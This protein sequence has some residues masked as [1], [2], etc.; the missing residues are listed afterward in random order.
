VADI[1]VATSPRIDLTVDQPNNY[2]FNPELNGST[3]NYS[4]V[5]TGAP[6]FDFVKRTSDASAAYAGTSGVPLDSFARR[7]AFAL[8]FSDPNIV[9]SQ[10]ITDQSRILYMRR[11]T[12]RVATSA[13]FLSFDTNSYPVVVQGH[14]YSVIDAYTTSEFYPNSQRY[15]SGVLG[16][17]FK[18]HPFNYIR[19]SVKAVVDTYDGSVTLYVVDKN[20][21]VIE[22]Y[23]TAFPELFTDA[24]EISSELRAHLRYP[25]DIFRVQTDMWG[26]YHINDANQ[27]YNKENAWEPPPPPTDRPQNIGA[28]AAQ[29]AQQ[30]LLAQPAT[31]KSF[32]RMAPPR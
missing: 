26:R 9:I 27:F 14:T 30:A 7:A 24:S 4:I 29:Q 17:D 20:D 11:V 13:P 22:A 21:P 32:V 6:E 15:G 19:N 5:K 25:E 23:Q 28:T 8:R 31:N 16:S 18:V 12:E 2:Y 1:P 10:Y 3:L